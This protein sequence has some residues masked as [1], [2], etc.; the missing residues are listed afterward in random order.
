MLY[1]KK[2]Q[3]MQYW[4]LSTGFMLC[5]RNSSAELNPQFRGCMLTHRIHLKAFVFRVRPPC[6]LRQAIST[7][8]NLPNR[9]GWLDS[10]PQESSISTP[11]AL[12]LQ[13]HT[14]LNFPSEGSGMELGSLLSTVFQ[15][16]EPSMK[17]SAL[18]GV[19][20]V[21]GP[22]PSTRPFVHTQLSLTPQKDQEGS[23]GAGWMVLTVRSS[24]ES[25]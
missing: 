1:T 4:E 19:G 3:L 17:A 18:S 12:G 23:Q 13:S 11:S 10:G 5:V 14:T 8:W 2:S 15:F 22:R 21:R 24:R 6:L 7:A 9:L 16:S 20:R 25:S